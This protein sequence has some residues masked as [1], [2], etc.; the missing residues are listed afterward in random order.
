M[1]VPDQIELSSP[2]VVPT[3]HSIKGVGKRL[4]GGHAVPPLPGERCF[5]RVFGIA[6][7]ALLRGALSMLPAF[8]LS[9]NPAPPN[10]VLAAYVAQD[11]LFNKR[12]SDVRQ[13]PAWF[14]VGR[15]PP[16][17]RKY[18]LQTASIS[19]MELATPDLRGY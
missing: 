3:R 5:A 4:A 18:G 8:C 9:P 2:A 1:S 11:L 6:L 7:T 19:G 16:G 14:P 17:T 12:K 13:R 10:L 15:Q